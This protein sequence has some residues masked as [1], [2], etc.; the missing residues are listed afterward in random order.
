[1]VVFSVHQSLVGRNECTST[2]PEDNQI[3]QSELVPEDGE[4]LDSFNSF[5]GQ[6]SVMVRNKHEDAFFLIKVF[7]LNL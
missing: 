6:T 7:P 3:A 4:P 5:Y 1:M 2:A